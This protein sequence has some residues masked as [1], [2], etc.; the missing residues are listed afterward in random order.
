MVP[1]ERRKTM[2]CANCGSNGPTVA[3]AYL[4]VSREE[5]E[6][7]CRPCG[8]AMIKAYPTVWAYRRPLSIVK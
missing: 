3:L 4:V 8:D 1:K 5:D 2:R 6:S 7:V